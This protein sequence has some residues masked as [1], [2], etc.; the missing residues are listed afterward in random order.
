MV[1]RPLEVRI[2]EALISRGSTIATA[3]SCTGGL[4]SY[5]ITSVA[6]S[7]VYFLGGVVAYSNALKESCLGVPARVLETYGA[8]SRECALAMA[9]GI[10][11]RTGAEVGVSTTG[12]AGPSGA[13]ETKPVGLVYVA[14]VTSVSEAVEEHYFD[15]QRL[16]NMAS[17]VE[18]ALRLAIQQIESNPLIDRKSPDRNGMP[19]AEA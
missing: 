12:I 17:S 16:E 9:W 10:W 19:R 18:A 14:C 3:E 15:G 4:V 7:S 6:G 8:V 5:R 11:S 2:A 1:E 13:T